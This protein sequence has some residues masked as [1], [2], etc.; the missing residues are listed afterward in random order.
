[1]FLGAFHIYLTYSAL[2]TLVIGTVERAGILII[3]AYVIALISERQAKAE[4]S[5]RKSEE[6]YRS[7]VESTSDLISIVDKE[8]KYLYVNNIWLSQFG[9]LKTQILGKTFDTFHSAEETKN[10]AKSVKRVFETGSTTEYE[11][12]SKRHNKWYIETLSAIKDPATKDIVA[13]SIISKDITKRRQAEDNLKKAYKELKI[14][15]GQLIQNE[16]MAALGRLTSG[17]AHQ[18][19]NPLSIILMGV[20]YLDITLSKK[21]EQCKESINAIKQAVDR[22]DKIISDILH[23]SRKME[24][25][26][27]TVDL[28]K[29]LD[30]IIELFI[31]RKNFDSVKIHQNYP[32][33]LVKCTADKNML[34]Q[35]IIN[36]LNNAVE[37]IQKGGEIKVNIF[38]KIASKLGNKVGNRI[39]DY[40]KIGDKIAVIEIE[41]TGSGIPED[42]LPKIFEPFFTT[43]EIGMGT[44][45]GLSLAHL[46]I[47][48]HHGSID[49]ESKVN[50]G[51]KF[52]IN[53]Q[54]ANN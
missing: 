26:F 48:H 11:S 3:L 22:T 15:Q 13:V 6:K 51:T 38:Y 40:F 28:C 37:A 44:G 54:P 35:V 8:C 45:L 10:F 27:E 30:D 36:L 34:Q 32:K 39:D 41:D 50:K 21:D 2:G 53:L 20:E 18:I 49:V 33:E 31:Y 42:L 4:I 29:L 25:N 7:F 24:L 19:R 14:T 1:M 17:I 46:I 9:L 52:I 12:Y 43:K 5:V 23:F 47:D 16:K